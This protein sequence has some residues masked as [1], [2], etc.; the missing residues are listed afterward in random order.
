M[1]KIQ[2]IKFPLVFDG[3]MGTYYPD[4]S[5]RVMPECEMAN[6][7]DS[8]VI[9]EIH[10]EYVDAG[11]M[12]IKTNTFQANTVSLGTDF[13]V[14]KNVIEAG[15]SLAKRAVKNTETL[16]F[17]DIGPIPGHDENSIDEHKEIIDIFLENG[18]NDF[19][20][21][22]FSEIGTLKE[23]AKYIKA[24]DENAF[25]ITSFAVGADGL[26]RTGEVGEDLLSEAAKSADIDAVGFNCVSGPLR[27]REYIEK[28]NLPEKIISIMPNGGY[29]TVIKNRTY[30]SA[31]KDYFSNATLQFLEYGVQIIGGC[32]GTRPEFIR[33]ITERISEYRYTKTRPEKKK[34]A[35][36]ETPYTENLFRNKLE[37]GKKP[38]VVEFDPPKDLNMK[39][40]MENV[41]ALS[42]SG[43][44]GITIADCPVARVRVDASLTAYKIKNEIGIEPIVHMTCRDRNV[45]ASKALLLGL[46]LENIL[47][48]ITITGDPVPTAE[49]DE[50]KS[51]FQF[52]STKFATLVSDMNEKIFTN[53]MNIGGALNLNANKFDLE[54]K[55]AQA[56]EKAGVNVFYTQPVISKTAVE[57][58][59]I[60]RKE[61]KSYIMGG[62]M[63][64]VSYKNALFMNSEAS[65][66]RLDDDIIERYKGLERKEAS[67][68]A[69]EITSDFMRKIEDYV[70]GYYIITPFSRVEIVGEL[71]QL[72]KK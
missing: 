30:Y 36:L 69:V 39:R 2:N 67:R 41:K 68:L 24:K 21:E 59:K 52:N 22:T 62:V 61:L 18:I 64:I 5:K 72:F 9:Y 44:D 55:R 16:V 27:L 6:L 10:K 32:C 17:A 46:N 14:V 34:H 51:V 15:L 48:I 38:I 70:D 13:S 66:I 60:A 3:A 63:P 11:A 26:T 58:L 28:I 31:N 43:A 20:F 29:P 56:K 37:H 42:N 33:E 25:I 1:T 40:Y 8:E 12:A 49:K 19:L 50:V 54:I 47:N 23:L 57:N 7:F 4:K 45:N 35:R 53:K 65:G 71:I